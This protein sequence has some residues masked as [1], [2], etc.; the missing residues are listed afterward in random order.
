VLFEMLTG[1]VPFK[2][3]NQVAV[4][5][6]HVREELPDVQMLRPEASAALAAVV[7]RATAKD[8]AR[9]YLDASSL[10]ADL[11]D[12]L[13]IETARAGQATGEATA[14]LRTLPGSTRRRLPL[15]MRVAP[16]VALALLVLVGAL[17]A[18]AFIL[19]RDNAER[20]T[21]PAAI[22]PTQGLRSVNL[23]QGAAHDYD[24]VGGD[25]EHPEEVS[26]AIDDQRSSS[27]STETYT[28]RE[29]GKPGV[30]LYLDAR[31]GVA[32]R[33]LALRTP[34]PGWSGAVYAATSGPPRQLGEG[35]TQV[36]TLEDVGRRERV[37]LDTNGRAYRFY[38]VW[39]TSLP[40]EGSKVEIADLALFR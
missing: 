29:L 36:A 21:R 23:G 15:R 16:A 24:P 2:G 7:D 31:P 20:G 17:A 22:K 27:W 4:A 13:A 40:P 25:G 18:G 5:M 28:D 11:E 19:A 30:G 37:R 8:L 33:Q 39:I 10:V 6:R 12:V 35:W 26:A 32:A 3:D 34:T 38:L 14:V 1:D 9:R